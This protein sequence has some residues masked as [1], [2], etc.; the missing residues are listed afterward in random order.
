MLHQDLG[1]R[2]LAQVPNLFQSHPERGVWGESGADRNGGD[3]GISQLAGREPRIQRPMREVW[4]K[5]SPY[6]FKLRNSKEGKTGP[7]SLLWKQPTKFS[8]PGP[9][10]R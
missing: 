2:P 1:F 3:P 7:K 4:E 10:Q 8:C 6:I 5:K 9:T